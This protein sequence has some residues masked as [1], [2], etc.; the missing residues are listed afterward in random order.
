MISLAFTKPAP[1]LLRS[2][3]L[4]TA[5]GLDDVVPLHWNNNIV[6]PLHEIEYIIE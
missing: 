2:W 1:D 4:R 3:M 6:V 5:F